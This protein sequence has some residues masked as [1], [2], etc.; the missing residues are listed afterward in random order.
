MKA[1]VFESNTGHTERYA[2]ILAEKLGVPCYAIKEASGSVPKGESVF[3]LGWVMANQICGLKKASRLWDVRAVGAVGICPASDSNSRIL[4]KKNKTDAP[5]FYLRGGVDYSK[6]KGL[7][8]TLLEL[9]RD[10]TARE[11]KP[12]NAELVRTLTEGGDFVCEEN[13]A[14]IVTFGLMQ[15]ADCRPQ[16]GDSEPKA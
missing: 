12:E 14:G 4:A 1:I 3:F 2:R 13:L 8:R 16:I 11:N 9:V 6:L 10:N 7:K 5:I 15:A